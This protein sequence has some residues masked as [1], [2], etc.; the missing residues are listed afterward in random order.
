MKRRFAMI[1]Y[2]MV[3][4]LFVLL[5]SLIGKD[6]DKLYQAIILLMMYIFF[7]HE[8]IYRIEEYIGKSEDLEQQESQNDSKKSD[9]Y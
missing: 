1:L 9:E 5:I 6:V 2:G 7:L 3:C 8:R 4:F